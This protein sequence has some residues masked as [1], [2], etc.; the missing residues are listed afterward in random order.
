M[1]ELEIVSQVASDLA[2]SA[3]TTG[4]PTVEHEIEP[5]DEGDPAAEEL[6]SAAEDLDPAAE[7][8]AAEELESAVEGP[9]AAGDKRTPA[10]RPRA[11]ARA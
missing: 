8:P 2:A 7:E 1:M 9:T 10:A 5:L 6:E 11:P 3:A 4:A